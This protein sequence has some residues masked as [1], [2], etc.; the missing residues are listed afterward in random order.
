MQNETNIPTR[1]LYWTVSC[2]DCKENISDLYFKYIDPYQ[3]LHNRLVQNQKLLLAALHTPKVAVQIV[4]KMNYA[5][6]LIHLLAEKGGEMATRLN[7]ANILTI[8]MDVRH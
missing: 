3:G 5:P 7:G 8:A 4:Y 1:Q 6:H 2:F